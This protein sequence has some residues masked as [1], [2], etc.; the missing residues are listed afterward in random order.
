MKKSGLAVLLFSLSL[1]QACGVSPFVKAD[2]FRQIKT[3][4]VL[5]LASN[6]VIY[7]VDDPYGGLVSQIASALS[8]TQV[9]NDTLYKALSDNL[10]KLG[11]NILDQKQFVKTAAYLDIKNK[12]PSYFKDPNNWY[13]GSKK[14][15]GLRE[16]VLTMTNQTYIEYN[17]GKKDKLH[18][19]MIQYMGKIAQEIGVDAVV[20]AYMDNAYKPSLLQFGGIGA[21][22]ARASVA[23]SFIIIDKYGEIINWDL[24]VQDSPRTV[25][26][27][28]T[29]LV[30]GT[31]DPRS[32]KFIGMMNEAIQ[33]HV[34]TWYTTLLKKLNP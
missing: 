31:I 8:V 30:A 9:Y 34:Q 23:T 26:S 22:L 17:W 13:K 29:G 6:P 25:S 4:A 15:S 16:S 18:T 28:S 19:E 11:W 12:L 2:K 20:I 27:T 5:S 14:Y 10:T 3:V 24:P 32:E 7:N 21:G 33:N 1:L